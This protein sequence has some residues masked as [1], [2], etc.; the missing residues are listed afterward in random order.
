MVD[1]K[2][3]DSNNCDCSDRSA[4]PVC[5][6]PESG[7]GD[8]IQFINTCA[9]SLFNCNNSEQRKYCAAYTILVLAIFNNCIPHIGYVVKYT[10]ECVLSES[11]YASAP[12]RMHMPIFRSSQLSG[13]ALTPIGQGVSQLTSLSKSS[14][15][16]IIRS[17]TYSG[18]SFGPK[19][20]QAPK[21]NLVVGSISKPEIISLSASSNSLLGSALKSL[22]S[23]GAL[24]SYFGQNQL[25]SL[26]EM[27]SGQTLLS[28]LKSK[29]EVIA[30]GKPVGGHLTVHHRHHHIQRATVTTTSVIQL[31]GDSISRSTYPSVGSDMSSG[32]V[33]ATLTVSSIS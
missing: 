22:G 8:V 4:E 16:S 7:P 28:G 10:G 32:S 27:S 2:S 33:S 1:V 30:H 24:K 19:G 26:H 13:S 6:A 14:K 9:L 11:A 31:S 21:A 5:G 29:S 15:L 3:Y 23:L 20:S 18:S 17:L 12:V 25:D